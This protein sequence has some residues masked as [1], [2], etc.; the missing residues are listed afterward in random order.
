M[1]WK[2]PIQGI[3]KRKTRY[4]GDQL[5]YGKKRKQYYNRSLEIKKTQPFYKE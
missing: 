4:P 1:E 3:L 5:R 2:G